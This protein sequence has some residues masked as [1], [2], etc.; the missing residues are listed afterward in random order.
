MYTVVTV[1]SCPLVE[2]SNKNAAVVHSRRIFSY[3]LVH[4][5]SN[6]YFEYAVP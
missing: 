4:R 3:F 6:A 5:F 2:I 1:K